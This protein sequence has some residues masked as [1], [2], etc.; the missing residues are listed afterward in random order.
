M[1]NKTSIAL[2]DTNVVDAGFK[3]KSKRA[4]KQVLESLFQKYAVS[5]S[6]YLY[7]E[8]YRGLAITK[9]PDAKK[10]V[11][12]FIAYPVDEDILSIAAALY[13]CYGC[14][15]QTKR[16]VK[17]IDDGDF[18]HAATAFKHKAVVIT[19]NRKDYPAPYFSELGKHVLT[20][21]KG[22]PIVFYELLPDLNYLNKML[23]ICYPKSVH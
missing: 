10:A 3:T 21:E 22:T 6:Q 17:A 18:I 5:I 2:L 8:I 4:T 1:K 20:D 7:F 23:S 9:I 13:T 16:D 15:D 11:D 19:A 12:E 14:D